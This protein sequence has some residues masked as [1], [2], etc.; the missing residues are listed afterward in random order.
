M[1]PSPLTRPLSGSP[2]PRL[3]PTTSN[4]DTAAPQQEALAQGMFLLLYMPS[5][6]LLLGAGE[7]EY[8]EVL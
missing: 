3:E 6:S 8:G 7:T 5:S 2:Y 4:P 1:A